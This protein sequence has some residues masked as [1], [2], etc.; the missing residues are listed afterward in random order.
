MQRALAAV[1]LTAA[2]VFSSAAYAGEVPTS[3]DQVARPGGDLPGDPKIALV[4][5]AGGFSDPSLS[6]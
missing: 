2:M 1:S 5:V 6:P 3:V 4:K